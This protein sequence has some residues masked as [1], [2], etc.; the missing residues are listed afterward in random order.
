MANATLENATAMPPTA[1]VI[2]KWP[3]VNIAV[4]I[5]F[6]VGASASLFFFSSFPL[7]S[8]FVFLL[9]NKIVNK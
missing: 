6:V 4:C 9:G 3:Q 2:A 1:A 5:N 7:L 8:H